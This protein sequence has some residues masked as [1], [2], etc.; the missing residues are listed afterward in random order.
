MVRVAVEA[1]HQQDMDQLEL[2]LSRLYQADP[3]V[4]VRQGS[5]SDAVRCDASNGN[6]DETS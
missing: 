5:G 4:E 3:A 1:L 6:I 2:G